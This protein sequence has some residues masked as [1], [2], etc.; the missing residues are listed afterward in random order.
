MRSFRDLNP[1]IVG[2]ISVALIG[3]AVGF[4]FMVAALH[5][6]EDSYDV[7]AIFPDA[8][9][10]RGGEEVRVAGVQVGRIAKVVPDR[11]HGNVRMTLKIDKG[12][13]LARDATA[14]L[15]LTTLLG[16][17]YVRMGGDVPDEGPYLAD[18]PETDRV[19]PIERTKVPFDI[20]ELTT[21]STRSIQQTDTEKLNQL[22]V[23]LADITEGNA[24]EIGRLIRGVDEVSS[25]IAAR[26]D[27]LRQ[28]IRRADTL[29][30]LLA[31]KDETL[32]SL[33]D[34][35]RAILALVSARRADLAYA[36]DQ[37]GA[38]ISEV[39]RVIGANESLLDSILDTLHPTLDILDRHQETVDRSLAVLGPGSLGLARS[40]GRGPWTDIYVRSLGPDAL[41]IIADALSEGP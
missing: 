29:A 6:L 10:V 13:D 15:A 5:L 37:G 41:G 24:D 4:A 20:F 21:I 12:V 22:I 1:Y 36:I 40:G 30:E 14:E 16:S 7:T 11:Q 26:D 38:A 8:A 2:T 39:S 18:V 9:G 25:A 34:Q 27:Q 33:I 31:D 28:L 3:A 35:S 17:K 23:S 32:V 19:I